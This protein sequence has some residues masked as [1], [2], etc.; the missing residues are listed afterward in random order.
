MM[1]EIAFIA[2]IHK[3][4]TMVD[5]GIRVTLDLPETAIQRMTE[6][7]EYQIRGV[8]ID[9]RVTEHTEDGKPGKSRKVHI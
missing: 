9:V 4:Q 6:L 7:A 3:V 1:D 8:A 2:A 5:G